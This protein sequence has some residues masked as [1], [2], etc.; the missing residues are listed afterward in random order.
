LSNVLAAVTV[1]AALTVAV[2]AQK[3]AKV[4][5]LASIRLFYFMAH[6][7]SAL[8]AEDQLC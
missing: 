3:A 2:S 6:I 7:E 4:F 5:T 8:A 1:E